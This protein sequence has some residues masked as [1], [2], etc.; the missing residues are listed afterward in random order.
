[1]D[2]DLEHFLMPGLLG[3]G[4]ADLVRVEVCFKMFKCVIHIYPIFDHLFFFV[5]L[6]DAQT[7]L[8]FV[9]KVVGCI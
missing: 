4:D 2:I 6:G 3:K 1:M 9:N 7:L 8:T 5:L